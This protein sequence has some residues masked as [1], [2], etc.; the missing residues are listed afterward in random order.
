MQQIAI[1]TLATL[2]TGKPCEVITT[3]NVKDG[4]AEGFESEV[5]GEA[6]EAMAQMEEKDIM[7]ALVPQLVGRCQPQRPNFGA[8]LSQILGGDNANDD[9][10]KADDS[11]ET[12][13]Q[14]QAAS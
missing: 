6:L 2:V 12:A 1:A 10:G 11:A 7:A 14:E 8:F 9:D 3:P 4:V 13:P 5:K